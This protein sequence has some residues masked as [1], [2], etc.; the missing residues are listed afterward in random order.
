M[1]FDIKQG[2]DL[3]D[4]GTQAKVSTLLESE[5]PELLVLCPECKHWG[6]WYK[7]N[8]HRLSM[9]DQLRN[10][11]QAEKQADFC[12][13][14]AEK[15]LK[16]GGRVLIEHP[17]SSQMWQYGP[18]KKVLKQMHLVPVD[19][20]AYVL[21][22]PDS[23]LP[24]KK[25]T[26]LAVSHEDMLHLARRCPGHEKHKLIEGKCSDGENLSSRMAHYTETFCREWL[27]CIRP[28]LSLCHFAC[29]EEQSENTSTEADV[30]QMSLGL[31][32][33]DHEVLAA[34][35]VDPSDQQ[36]RQ[37]LKKLHNNLG[38]A[39][40][41]DLVRVLKNAG[42]SEQAIRLATD[43]EKQCEVCQQRQRPT[44]C[45]PA[46]SHQFLSFNER[47]GFDVKQVPGWNTN[48][49]VKCLNIVD[50][51]SSF[52][53]MLPFFEQE[54]SEQ[55]RNLFQTRWVS[56]AGQPL[57]VLVDPA[58]TNTAE[59]MVNALETEGTRVLTTAAEAHN[60]LGK[61]EK[62]GH[63][64]EV[65][66]QKVLDQ[67][68]PRSREEFELCVIQTMNAK[69]DL[70]NQKGLSPNQLVFG[71]NPRVP[72]ELV[73]EMPCPVAATSPM[74]DE[75]AARSAAIR[76]QARA[77]LMLAQDSSVL[78]EALNAR[79]RA[80]RDFLAGDF[81][82][83]WR[84]QKYQKGVRLVGGR[85]YGAA[86]VMGRI[87][88][89]FLIHHRKNMFKVAPEHLRHATQ[90][91]KL[92]SQI[93]G[94]ELLG[95]SSMIQS[96]KDMLGH[97]FVDL[98]GQE[99][100]PQAEKALKRI[101]HAEDYWI[102]RGD[103]LCR[104]H[105]QARKQP[106]MP[107]VTD[108]VLRNFQLDDWRCTRFAGTGQTVVDKPWS[109]EPTLSL[110]P[111]EPWTG[112]TQFKINK[113]HPAYQQETQKLLLPPSVLSEKGEPRA[114]PLGLEPSKSVVPDPLDEPA[115]NES[116][117][118]YSQHKPEEPPTA[119]EYGPVR[120]RRVGKGP[121][122]FLFRLP[123]SHAD[124]VQDV[125]QSLIEDQHGTK[126]PHSRA[127]SSDPPEKSQKTEDDCLLAENEEAQPKCWEVL[128]AGFLK[129]QMQKELHH[130]NNPPLLQEKVD[131][132]KTCEWMT[133]RDEKEA[134]RV[135]PPRAAN[136]IRKQK[137]DR[138]MTSRFVITE[139]QEDELSK[140][141]ARWC[142]RGHHDPDLILKVLAGKCHSP[143]LAQL[144]RNILLQ[145]IVSFRW[146]MNLGDI[147]GAFLE[148]NVKEKALKN[149]VYAELPPGGVPGVAP[150][151]LVQ[152]LGNIYG[153][154]DAPHEWYQ[155]FDQ[156]ATSVGFTR[157][158]FDSC[159]YLCFGPDQMEACRVC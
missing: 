131:E 136:E 14:Q 137:P 151:S 87:G 12:A 83:Y 69:N 123:E 26:G 102:H 91:E 86:V 126:R 20:C 56:W 129:K 104:V 60:Q 1:A 107:E 46:S 97:Q 57:E 149:P 65:V 121:P 3:T 153:A 70:L 24:V 108:P 47:I 115:R 98:S 159:L 143:T 95:L 64:F 52:Q 81:V 77:S 32:V 59:A 93:D 114:S 120:A 144:S 152:V 54:T 109:S 10:K 92:L 135:I 128:M 145:L 111:V 106:F 34:S 112:E 22:D 37:L 35:S 141:K 73:Q 11:K 148:A 119:M 100:P 45:L 94:R 61:V 99:G 79:P 82:C 27:K 78:R 33:A 88:R 103:L 66:L 96:G 132:A 8:Q 76:A 15:Q 19:M 51:A 156:T 44:P 5:K 9:I 28:S 39:S 130:S 72:S 23:K 67:I 134:L 138:I 42:G 140:I 157:S 117:A 155:E 40:G 58:R 13:K 90:E 21:C 36:V 133:L 48:Q 43:F 101:E 116:P 71:R 63:L 53:V 55:L 30:N 118:P 110:F 16:R 127:S 113:E 62:H 31:S 85:W 122:N 25:P 75:Q 147:K 50:Y 7:L 74:H 17:W 2:W 158:V 6:G 4:P 139:K 142:L 80:D 89:N 41:R 146:E 84:S 18:M 105:V 125:V 124:D 68:Q 49:K 29:L 38:H 150:G 154:N